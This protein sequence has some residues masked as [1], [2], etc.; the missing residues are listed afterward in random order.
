MGKYEELCA[1]IGVQQEKCKEQPAFYVGEQL[2]DMARGDQFAIELLLQDLQVAAMSII[3][4]EKKIKEYADKHRKGNCAFVPPLVAE[5]ILRK[6]YGI[7]ANGSGSVSGS[8]KRTPAGDVID[9]AD[10]L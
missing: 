7:P 3:E 1:L 9:V 5:E 10:Y 4:A 2:K 8:G 6:F